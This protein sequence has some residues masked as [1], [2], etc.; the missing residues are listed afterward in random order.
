MFLCKQTKCREIKRLLKR[1]KFKKVVSELRGKDYEALR[2]EQSE[3][4]Y[5]ALLMAVKDAV[6]SARHLMSY[7]KKNFQAFASAC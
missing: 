4:N 7:I 5:D 2:M 6:V 3:L 1:L